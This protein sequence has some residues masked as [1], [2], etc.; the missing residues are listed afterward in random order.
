M[1]TADLMDAMNERLKEARKYG[2]E[3]EVLTWAFM[4]L[5]KGDDY[6]ILEALDYGLGEWVK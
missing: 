2:L 5:S 1:E 6:K 3:M 4:Q